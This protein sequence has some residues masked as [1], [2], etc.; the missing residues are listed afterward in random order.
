MVNILKIYAKNQKILFVDD[1]K[2]LRDI[3]ADLLGKFFSVVKVASDGKEALEMYNKEHFDI[4]ITDLN[5][6]VM[7]GVELSSAIKS[8]NR[9]QYIIVL[10]GFIDEFIIDLIRIG[11]SDLMLKPIK[12][13]LFIESLARASEN[14]FLKEEFDKIK[15]KKVALRDKKIAYFAK[16]KDEIDPF[17]AMADA[18]LMEQGLIQDEIGLEGNE[19][20]L[21]EFIMNNFENIVTYN[22]NLGIVVRDIRLNDFSDKT[23]LDLAEIFT[24]CRDIFFK[25][26]GF[27]QITSEFE[28]LSTFFESLSNEELD[29]NSDHLISSMETLFETLSHLVMAIFVDRDESKSKHYIPILK[30]NTQ[31][32]INV[33]VG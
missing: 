15:L 16:E 30:L 21:D 11:I 28:K 8:I 1:E 10:S 9:D 20:F 7:N 3:Y 24:S 26:K 14:L 31:K 23:L 13:K 27:S 2:S 18:I 22:D 4:V 17:E 6:P 25:I 32:L 29:D 12:S 5:M 33:V 19:G